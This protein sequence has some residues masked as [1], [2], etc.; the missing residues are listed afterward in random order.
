MDELFIFYGDKF[1][2]IDENFQIVT[3]KEGDYISNSRNI[4]DA[5]DLKRNI[6]KLCVLNSLGSYDDTVAGAKIYCK[7]FVVPETFE[8][9]SNNS[10]ERSGDEIPYGLKRKL[11]VS[12]N[13]KDNSYLYVKIGKNW[14]FVH[15]NSIFFK[16]ESGKNVS[17]SQAESSRLDISNKKF[18]VITKGSRIVAINE[19]K[20]KNEAIY[21]YVQIGK[22]WSFVHPT[23]IYWYDGITRKTYFDA[24]AEGKNLDDIK[25]FNN[26]NKEISSIYTEYEY[27]FGRIIEKE[28]VDLDDST[29]SVVSVAE[30]GKETTLSKSSINKTISQQTFV[31][32]QVPDEK[33]VG[34]IKK[35]NKVK[36]TNFSSVKEFDQNDKNLFIS[37]TVSDSLSSHVQMVKIS[38]LVDED[39]LTISD[40]SKMVGK[41]VKIK[42][43][44]IVVATTEPLTFEQANLKYDTIK[45]YQESGVNPNENTCLRLKDGTYVNELDHVQ[46]MSFKVA[47]GDQFDKYLVKQTT[48]DGTK[49]VVVNADYF[50]KH[51][52]LKGIERESA[53]RILS[54][55]F[56][57]KNCSIVQTSSSGAEIEQCEFVQKIDGIDD[58]VKS[59]KDLYEGFKNSYK[60]NKYQLNHIYV[61]GEKKEID[62]PNIRYEY[63]DDQY[64][65][66]YAEDLQQFKAL[67]TKDIKINNGIMTGGGKYDIGEGIANH[68]SILG[69]TFAYGY[70]IAIATGFFIPI[71]GPIVAAAYSF[72]VIAAIPGIPIGNAIYGAVKNSSKTFV[73]KTEYNRSVEVKNINKEIQDLFKAGLEPTQFEDKYSRIMNKILS[74]SQTTSNNSLVVQNGSATVNSNNVNLAN[75]QIEEYNKKNNRL[76]RVTS[77][78]EK[79]KA[80]GKAVPVDLQSEFDELT[81][82]VDKLKNSTMGTSYSKD[83]RMEQLKTRAQSLQL[84]YKLTHLKGAELDAYCEEIGL[85]KSIIDHLEYNAELGLMVDGLSIVATE[86]QI[87]KKFGK[88]NVAEINAWK[89]LRDGLK[90]SITKV[91][92]TKTQPPRTTANTENDLEINRDEIE[93]D[94]E[95]DHNNEAEQEQ[96]LEDSFK[97]ERSELEKQISEITETNQSLEAEKSSL[98]NKIRELEAKLTNSLSPEEEENLKGQIQENKTK[99]EALETEKT[100]L[101][102]ELEKLLKEKEQAE[103][104]LSEQQ[105]RID[106]LVC[107]NGDLIEIN[108][109]LDGYKDK[110]D[111]TVT[112]LEELEK[113]K[114]ETEKSLKEQIGLKEE[115]IANKDKTIEEYDRQ[116]IDLK[117][118]LSQLEENINSLKTQVTDLTQENETLEQENKDLQAAVEALEEYKYKY[119]ET[120]KQLQDLE[121]EKEKMEIEL[122]DKLKSKDEEIAKLNENLDK[123]NE[124]IQGLTDDLS[125]LQERINGLQQNIDDLSQEN[126]TLKQ[127]NK[128]LQAAVETLKD[129]K[130]KYDETVTQLEELEKLKEQTEKSL[131][132]QIGL[133]EKEIKRLNENLETYNKRI[134]VLQKSESELNTNI[135]KLTQQIQSLTNENLD[136]KNKLNISEEENRLL[137]QRLENLKH[138]EQESIKSIAQLDIEINAIKEKINRISKEIEAKKQ[139]YKALKNRIDNNEDAKVIN[140]DLAIYRKDLRRIN[141]EIK[142]NLEKLNSFESRAVE[143]DNIWSIAV[144]EEGKE[145]D[146]KNKERSSKIKI[147]TETS[148]LQ[149]K[150]IKDLNIKNVKI[151]PEFIT[152]INSENKLKDLLKYRDASLLK[153]LKSQGVEFTD[154]DIEATISR[155]E[156]KHAEKKIAT[157][158]STKLGNKNINFILVQGQKYITKYATKS[159]ELSI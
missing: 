70:P 142:A 126:E 72:G 20:T 66:D 87:K 26:S 123:S 90:T 109:R 113:L 136:L 62:A 24:L 119:D 149:S 56:K 52:N 99:I 114:E 73:D 95:H 12:K 51:G 67:K 59:K 133:N 106:E 146:N 152:D 151:D 138:L 115:E 134:E 108:K 9:I 68:Y 45:T 10:T 91:K 42:E 137:K 33:N 15:K 65:N 71:V 23:E 148:K 116:I 130:N 118:N 43:G 57:D 2:K 159:A 27:I 101:E 132:E 4:K 82:D 94:L 154:E 78:I 17:Y 104:K 3:K 88:K 58:E 30:N 75:V 53:I 5:D 112:Q 97:E 128:D 46:P 143:I 47:T 135:Q 48:S 83:E 32:V 1:V 92:D 29:K 18:Y 147:L 6:S 105:R 39:G 140:K 117:E 37:V 155:I 107:E 122:N 63:T 25:F 22:K 38:D 141:D 74:L 34:K 93:Q 139:E 150:E 14:R 145:I 81:K 80:K 49:W 76:K 28:V 89:A 69:K 157:H 103:I 11:E 35:V 21:Y 50:R 144:T 86:K 13:K 111:E 54:C 84:Y 153:F 7:S 124:K 102:K 125:K 60:N 79:L 120:L 98:E 77:Q 40:I 36:T 44:N 16:D 127:E 61:D 121:Q 41:R 85:E 19:I 55:D 8:S 110:Y 129:Y 131:K 31:Q 64:L 100:R 156:E 96:R 158:H